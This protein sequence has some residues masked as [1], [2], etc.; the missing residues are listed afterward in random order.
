M[1]HTSITST[2]HLEPRMHK[3]IS[4]G[5]DAALCEAHTQRVSLGVGREDGRSPISPAIRGVRV[6]EVPHQTS[7]A[8]RR[9]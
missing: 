1:R 5:P 2:L 6:G 8:C 7:L 9:M 3:G 4:D